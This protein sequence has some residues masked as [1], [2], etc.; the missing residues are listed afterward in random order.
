MQGQRH[1]D[2]KYS[3]AG[4]RPEAPEEGHAACGERQHG[5]VAACVARKVSIAVRARGQNLGGTLE[6]L[7]HLHHLRGHEELST[8]RRTILIPDFKKFKSNANNPIVKNMSILN[9]RSVFLIFVIVTGSNMPQ[10]SKDRILWM[11][12]KKTS[13]GLLLMTI[14]G[15]KTKTMSLL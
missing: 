11:E 10:V 15:K 14:L 13:F 6:V 5:A 3:P 12:T 7:A 2:A 1:Q 8:P 9:R 4:I